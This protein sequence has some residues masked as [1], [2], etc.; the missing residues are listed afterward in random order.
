MRLF[1]TGSTGFI[2]GAFVREAVRRGHEVLALVRDGGQAP[3]APCTAAVGTL[4]DPPWREIESFE[5]E[6]AG[7][8]AWIA[9]PGVYMHS[10]ENE[11]LVDESKRLIAGLLER[12]VSRVAV[13]GT[14]IEYAPSAEPLDELT[15][16]CAPEFAYSRAKLALHDWLAELDWKPGTSWSW[17]RVFYPYGPGEHPGRLATD[18]GK[19]LAAGQDIELRTPDSVKD[20]IYIDDLARA[21]GDVVGSRLAGPV[22]IATGE[23]TSIR[24]VAELIAE[25]LGVASTRV[26]ASAPLGADPRP[27]LVARTDRLRSTGWRPTVPLATGLDR[28]VS[29]LEPGA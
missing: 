8:L 19:R 1:V 28:L 21:I 26:R 5:P 2:G 25:R 13:A 7:H 3:A 11:R 9:T 29:T 23:G 12:A 6:A 16:R 18:F 14:C 27:T 17:L 15:S 22:N 4:A 20:F 24:R 10:P